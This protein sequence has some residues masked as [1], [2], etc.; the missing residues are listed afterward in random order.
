MFVNLTPHAIV[1]LV[2]GQD[3]FLP[4]AGDPVRVETTQEAVCD[5]DGIPVVKTT[6]GAIV[7]LPEP[8][9]GY[10][11]VTSSMVAQAAAAA[12]RS[13]VVSPD[14]GPSA[15]RENGQVVAVTRFQTF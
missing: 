14:T 2:A 4:C 11:F 12:G 9:D 15:V 10:V 1:V 7:G 3:I 8:I 6:T 5:I 13:D